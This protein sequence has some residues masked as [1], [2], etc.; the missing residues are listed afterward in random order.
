MT[1]SILLKFSR[2]DNKALS[3]E[4]LLIT[5]LVIIRL[6]IVFGLNDNLWASLC[7]MLPFW[8]VIVNNH[9]PEFVIPIKLP[10]FINR[11]II[12][13]S[14]VINLFAGFLLISGLYIYLVKHNNQEFILFLSIIFSA[15]VSILFVIGLAKIIDGFRVDNKLLILGISF[16]LITMIGI[17]RTST[18]VPF[19]LIRLFQIITILYFCFSSRIMLRKKADTYI[20]HLYLGLLVYLG[21]N[22][23]LFY[24]GIDNPYILNSRVGKSV[25][26]SAIGIQS[27]R[28]HFPLAEGINQFGFVGGAGFVMSA[29]FF[30]NGLYDKKRESN[31]YFITIIGGLISG[32]IILA[33]DSRGAMLFTMLV[34]GLIV[35]RKLV[36]NKSI[37]TIV[38]LSQSVIFL[39][40]SDFLNNLP[41]LTPLAR[42]KSDMLSNRGFIWREGIDFLLKFQWT[43]LFGYGLSGHKAS[44]V[45]Y[46][47]WYTIEHYIKKIKVD[48]N[49][50]L[51]H[52][53]LQQI[54][55]YGYI[56]LIA[57]YAFL[58]FTGYKIIEYLQNDKSLNVYAPLY[59]LLLFMI[60]AGVVSSIPTFYSEE[61]FYLLPFIWVV[62]IYRNKYENE[63]KFEE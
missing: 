5:G 4:I 16:Y 38:V 55:D 59:A 45:V 32:W 6:P 11:L 48:S 31:L 41:F 23:I 57:S 52:F 25:M 35:L 2:I 26:Y 18:E 60:F 40:L 30:L 62:T 33:A 1:K 9:L 61:L 56:G 37:Y 20:W 47:Y 36:V 46:H 27:S 42:V 51:H 3:N 17:I 28:I 13:I 58:L 21:L 53:G 12:N 44:G 14:L 10:R 49:I 39:P 34:S 22:I 15:L 24:S 8:L 50:S 43:H 7:T 29:A 63:S 54:Y 19:L